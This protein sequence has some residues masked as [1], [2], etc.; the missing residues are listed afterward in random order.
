MPLSVQQRH[1]SA[2]YRRSAHIVDER[3]P[4]V[5]RAQDLRGTLLLVT[6]ESAATPECANQCLAFGKPSSFSD[7]DARPNGES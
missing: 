2:L 4:S 1:V 5:P 3:V 7:H 6:R